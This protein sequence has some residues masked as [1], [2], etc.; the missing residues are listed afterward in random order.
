M[1]VR[2]GQVLANVDA[3][4]LG[5]AML[6]AAQ[7]ARIGVTVTLVDDGVPRQA[8]ANEAAA[9]ILGWPL[10]ELLERDPLGTIV[11]EDR[12]HVRERIQ[13]RAAGEKGQTTYELVVQR[14]DG[15][16]VPIELTATH[17]TVEGRTAVVAFI[18]DI[19]ARKEAE[20]HRVHSEARFRELIESAPE[21]IGIV[22]DGRFVYVNRAYVTV[23][24]YPD[25]ESVYAVRLLDM[26]DPE[27]ETVRAAREQDTVAHH[28]RQPPQVYQ[29]RRHDGATVQLEVSSVYFEYEGKPAVL[30]IG[31]D[32]TERKVLERRL[33]QAD[34]LAALGTLAAGVAHEINNP[35]SY[36]MLNLE[37]VV[38]KL[39]SMH[40][41]AASLDGL[42]M[43]MTEARQGVERVSTIVRE[44]RSFSRLE[45]ET[46]CRIELRAVVE[47]ALGIVGHELRPRARIITS[48]EPVGEV[49][50]TEAR[51]EQVV[52]NLLLNAA[53]ALPEERAGTNEIRVSV[54]PDGDG[55][56]V[57]E[58][59]DNGAGIPPDVLPRIFD[60]FFTT[61]PVGL[62]TGLGLSICHGIVMS[63]GGRIAVYSE[64]GDG[65]AFRVRLPTV[66]PDAEG[67][68]AVAS[69]GPVSASRGPRARVLVIDDE[70]AIANTLRE[71]L[72]PEHEVVAATS[73]AQALATLAQADFDVVFCDVMMPDMSGMDLY[74]HL[75]VERPSLA[76]RV[77]F[78][79]GG[80][81]TE[82]TAEFLASVDNRRVEKPFSLGMVE[83]IVREMAGASG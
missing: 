23:L 14:K 48:Y 11:E 54:R 30:S 79:T 17:A 44:L 59:T 34:R 33:A 50:A 19:S 74:E 22:R 1:G 5:K 60:P 31:R 68:A 37:W 58:V 27:Q 57:L 83:G 45:G 76:R 4:V 67:E 9:D 35:L 52:V 12:A 40:N 18:L 73:G 24:G 63:L 42:M 16:R 20:R 29:V 71:L 25:P 65:A 70:L 43:M 3:G 28:T 7:A 51:L 55:H 82:R 13:R 81:F 26:L 2:A 41:D 56:A 66:E 62:G 75:R 39:P 46:R 38:R 64:P 47:S 77:V 61:K 15:R 49:L 8:Y 21:A 32:V 6:D 69:A 10:D 72:A 53:Q 36:V 80:A 78:M